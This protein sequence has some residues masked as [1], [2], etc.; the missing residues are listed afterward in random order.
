M[1]KQFNMNGPLSLK[2]VYTLNEME[3][4]EEESGCQR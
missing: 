1:K 3:R 4:L 2:C